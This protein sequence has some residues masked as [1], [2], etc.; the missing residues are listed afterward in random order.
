MKYLAVLA[1][2]GS[3]LAGCTTTGHKQDIGTVLGGVAGAVIGAELGGHGDSRDI[4]LAAGAII[5]AA[6]GSD[7]GKSLDRQDRFYMQR[8]QREAFEYTPSGQAATWRNPDTGHGGSVTP[9]P[10]YEVQDGEYCR[11]FTQEIEIGGRVEE[12]Y[13]TACRQPDGSWKIAS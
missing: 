6:V 7:I 10:A 13:G 9:R 1:M 2:A 4:G 11:E 3:L 8:A 12:G 5:G